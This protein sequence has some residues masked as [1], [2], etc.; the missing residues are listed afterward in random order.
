METRYPINSAKRWIYVAHLTTLNTGL[1]AGEI[2]GLKPID[3]VEG[4]DTL[5]IRCQFNRVTRDFDLIKGKRNSKSRSLSRHVTCNEYLR[6]EI[7]KL[8]S[9]K[10]IQNDETLFMTLAR[11]PVDHDKFQKIFKADLKAWGGKVIR[12]HDMRHT[13]TTLLIASGVD[14]KTVQSICG[15]EDI[16]T[17]MNYVH[18]IGDRIKEVAKTFSIRPEDQTPKKALTEISSSTSGQ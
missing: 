2:W 11:T 3:L 18:L 15:H 5:F 1:G 12:F 17:T 7:L 14:L 6:D 10:Q 8:I 16:K 4:G 13:A 9:Q